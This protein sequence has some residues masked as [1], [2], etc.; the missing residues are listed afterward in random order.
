MAAGAVLATRGGLPINVKYVFEGEEESSSVHLDAWLEAERDR[1]AGGRR[2]HQRHRLL[3]GQPAGDHAQPA[4][5]DV[6]PDRRRRDRGRPPFG[7]LRRRR[8]EPG[9]RAGPDHRGAQGSGR[10]DPHPR[11]ST[12]MSCRCP[13]PTGRRFAALPVRRGGV[14]RARSGSR[15]SS[16]R[17]ATR[18]SSGARRRPTLDVNGIW[19]G[20]Q[21]EGSKTII[22]AHAHAKVSCRLVA[23][24]DPDRIFEAFRAYVEEIAPPGVTTTV[25]LPRWRPAEPDAD[26]PSGDAGRGAGARGDVRAGAGLHPRGRLDPGL[27]Q[28]RR[29]SS[30][31]RSSCSGFTPPDDNAHAPNEWMDL[32]NYET[33]IR[34]IARMWDE[35][36]DL[37]R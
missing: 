6:R 14:P 36:V 15:R 37:P 4:R 32:R 21:G 28:L 11:A 3:R 23:D 34:T 9:Q 18:R 33:S 19:G 5:A 25:Q 20:F 24:Q 12:T 35:L 30:A 26:G 2:D 31:C 1:L 16:A 7:R 29:R 27:R 10:P 22:P 13:R 8:P 17:S